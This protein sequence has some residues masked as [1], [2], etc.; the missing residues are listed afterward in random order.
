GPRRSASRLGSRVFSDPTSIDASMRVASGRFGSYVMSPR[1]LS[2]SPRTFVIIK[3]RTEKP[4]L[5]CPGSRV[6]RVLEVSVIG[7]VLVVAFMV[8][9]LAPIPRDVAQHARISALRP[10]NEQL[11][12]PVRRS[13]PEARGCLRVNVRSIGGPIANERE[14]AVDAG[15]GEG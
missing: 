7:G 15:A 9:T 14:R 4:T 1:N 3:C 10:R 2:N 6:H 12:P 11:R 13:S 5:E 8:S